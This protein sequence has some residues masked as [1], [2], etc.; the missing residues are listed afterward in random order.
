MNSRQ[1]VLKTLQF[2]EPDKVPVTLAY[3]TPRGIAERYGK[4]YD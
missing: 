4:P 1:R 3:E 2:E